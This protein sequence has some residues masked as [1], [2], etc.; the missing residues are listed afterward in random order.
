MKNKAVLVP[1]GGALVIAVLVVLIVIVGYRGVSGTTA[2]A[3]TR[4]TP[5]ASASPSKTPSPKPTPTRTAKP[6]PTASK[7]PAKPR[8]A[9]VLDCTVDG[10]KKEFATVQAVWG[11]AA[12]SFCEGRVRTSG[13][14]SDVEKEAMEITFGPGYDPENLRYLYGVCANT[15]GIYVD[16]VRSGGQ[17]KYLMGAYKLCPDHPKA[18]AIEATIASGQQMIAEEEA[19]ENAVAE[20]RQFGPGKYLIGVDLQPGV[21]QSVGEKVTDCY[22][23]ISDAQ[24]NIIENNFISV[25]PQF[26]I[27]VPEW[28]AGFTISG[29]TFRQIS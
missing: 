8:M 24:G 11:L 6:T 17:A 9:V 5:S 3:D 14:L 16:Y 4:T 23:E 7:P 29:C 12:S 25:A 13:V 19:N 20:V 26:S 15:E 21:W 10:T 28:A 22:W 18:A 1:L 2:E 27:T